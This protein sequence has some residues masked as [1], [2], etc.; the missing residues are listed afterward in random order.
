MRQLIYGL[1]LA[2]AMYSNL[3]SAECRNTQDFS[4]WLNDF[5]QEAIGTGLA[6]D[7]VNQALAGITLDQS[8]I[9]SDRSQEVFA[10]NFLEFA[11]K[12]V[13]NY[14]LSNGQRQMQ[15]NA[16]LFQR[17]EQEYGV[18]APMLTALWALETDLGA[19]TGDFPTLRSLATL[20]YDCRRPERFRPEL[21]HALWLVQ[22]GDQTPASMR[23]AWAG[24][25]GQLQ[26]LPSGYNQQGVDFDGDGHRDLI[27]SKA[28]ALASA[29]NLLRHH[30]WRAGEPWLLE[31]RVPK[32]MD[33]SK[34][35]LDNRLPLAEWSAMGVTEADGDPLR[36]NGQ[37]ALVLPVGRNGP[38]FLA[39][40]NFDVI[41]QWNES[42][43]YATTAAYL[44]TRL[45]GAP[46]LFT[47]NGPIAK[48]SVNQIRQMQSQLAARG[49]AVGKIDGII[50]EDTRNAIRQLQQ[51]LG[52]P[53]DGYPD[54]NFLSKL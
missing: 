54:A 21:I 8:V 49:L 6:P 5:K 16:K 44:A 41:R 35:R 14:R 29:A 51:Q 38:A 19:V 4:S 26:F 12:K 3:A 24:E 10:Q 1:L 20:A 30:G 17:I 37:A 7:I 45:A 11:G 18:P 31:V 2:S 36:P 25:L 34:A 48:L 28:D 23:G 47:G 42:T 32:D 53:A 43:V 39:F 22:K 27:R 40:P 46:A 15:A 52:L 13:S 50:G 9:Q 33:W